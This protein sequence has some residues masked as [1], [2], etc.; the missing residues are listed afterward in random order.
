MISDASV[1]RIIY[2]LALV[3]AICVKIYLAKYNIKIEGIDFL[4]GVIIFFAIICIF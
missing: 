2:F 3:F 1:K 4:L